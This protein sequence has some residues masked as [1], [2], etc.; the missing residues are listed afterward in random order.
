MQVLGTLPV[1][2]ANRM[3]K[4]GTISPIGQGVKITMTRAEHSSESLWKNPATGKDEVHLGGEA[5]GFIIEFKLWHQGDTGVFDDM[6]LLGEL[7]KPDRLLM[8]IGGGQFVM[9]PADAAYAACELIR[10][11]AVI[12][13]TAAP[14][15]RCRARPQSSARRW[16]PARS[17][18]WRST[19]A[20]RWSSDGSGGRAVPQP[21]STPSR[22]PPRHAPSI[23]G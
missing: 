8:P 17:R 16:A 15:Q 22:Q 13:C 11:K 19:P 21:C 20:R 6:K 3:N 7:Q 23:Q 5:C 1:P 4:Y 14:T 9:N 12:P 2:Q 10:P 18:G